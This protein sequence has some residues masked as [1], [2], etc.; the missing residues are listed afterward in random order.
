MRFGT[1]AEMI[2]ATGVNQDD[3][4]IT[5]QGVYVA[6]YVAIALNAPWE[7]A[8]TGAT[9]T[10]RN[11]AISLLLGS[12]GLARIGRITG[13][14]TATPNGKIP[15]IH[16]VNPVVDLFQLHTDVFLDLSVSPSNIDTRALGQ[17]TCQ[18]GD[19]LSCSFGPLWVRSWATDYGYLHFEFVDDFGGAGAS[20]IERF[21][22][23][24]P[25]MSPSFM[26]IFTIPVIH[27][28]TVSGIT[29]WQI[30]AVA[31]NSVLGYLGFDPV[32]NSIGSITIYR[33]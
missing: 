8:G 20:T 33:P 7:F 28:V 21:T 24:V 16:Q 30:R 17:T 29:R 23:R 31:G 32:D 25:P 10:W 14:D 26:E 18:V 13:I 5:E 15:L 4:W 11:T 22:L 6:D 9:V 27:Q 12:S 3:I 2:A 19:I 1:I